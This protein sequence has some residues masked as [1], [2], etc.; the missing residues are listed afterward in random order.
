[1]RIIKNPEKVRAFFDCLRDY[2]RIK[3]L[4][5]LDYDGTLAP[6]VVDRDRAYPYKGIFEI[7]DQ[8]V[9]SKLNKIVIVT[10]RNAAKIKDFLPLKKP[11]EVWGVHG[12]ER[13]LHDGRVTR[14][15]ITEDVQKAFSK[16]SKWAKAHGMSDR[17]EQKYGSLAFHIRGLEKD[18]TEALLTYA[19][20][21]L[22]K[23]SEGTGLEIKEFDG[24]IEL[25]TQGV[26]KG[27][28]IRTILSET[29]RDTIFS[30][31]GDDMTDEDAFAA[32]GDLGVSFLVR[33]A[34]RPTKADVWLK[35]PHELKDVLK[36]FIVKPKSC[37]AK[38]DRNDF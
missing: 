34:Y 18:K 33:P 25:R 24:G 13:V 37:T 19:K 9:S 23:I 14:T 8:I 12:M 29:E 31:F 30:Y 6:F 11:Y 20:D 38:R 17:I 2:P 5:M 32:L 27:T 36:R 1:M 7:L 16:A 26:D 28:A 3:R 4:I 10:G 15:P 21:S 35:P 22:K